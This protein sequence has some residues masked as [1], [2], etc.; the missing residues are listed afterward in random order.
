MFLHA[1]EISPSIRPNIVWITCEDM[2]PHLSCFGEKLINTPNLDKL[3]SD[4]VRYTNFYTVSGVCAP[5]R[6]SI[7]TG[8]YPTSIGAN[9]MRNYIPLKGVA[10]VKLEG[11]PASYS[12]VPPKEVKCFPE[13]LRKA[14]Y[15]C[16]NNPKED[17]QFQA[18]VTAWDESSP[19]A[20]WKNR[21]TNQPFFAVFNLE[22][23]HESQIWKRANFPLMVNP[24]EIKVPSYYPNVSEV[25]RDI[26]IHLS[27]VIEMDKQVGKLIKEL[28][29]AGLYEE[30]IIFFYSDHGDGLPYVKREI[31][32]RGLHVPL[33]IKFPKQKYAGTVDSSLLSAIDLAPSI[34]SLAHIKVP[35]YMQGRPFLGNINKPK[36]KFLFAARD[37]MD[38]HVDRVR[39]VF[40]ERFQYLRN[41][42]PELPYYQNLAYR[43]QMPS[44]S[45]IIE[46]RDSGMLNEV[47][48][49]WF[50]IKPKEELYDTKLDPNQLHNLINE[51]S[52]SKLA[53][54]MSAELDRWLLKYPDLNA[55]PE[56]QL[57]KKMW[58]GKLEVPHTADLKLKKIGSAFKVLCKTEGASIGYRIYK[59]G[60]NSNQQSFKV[61]QNELLRI[62]AD[63]E[64]EIQ[65]Q[66]IG[67]TASILKFS[68]NHK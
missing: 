21:S 15:Y 28:K 54:K 18:P 26:A 64:I 61:Y 11:V 42:F 59:K 50:S 67:Y 65:A 53:N 58:N 48:K 55:I 35:N 12:V 36:V 31:T 56:D 47:Q 14:G 57:R 38:E 68:F 40:D 30:T 52:F 39:T 19:K 32:K 16:T 2:S 45:R 29:D 46:L 49:R 9:N 8:M 6:N 10:E 13:Y 63:E 20:H 37:R 62:N 25:R 1:Q 66:R 44:M 27:N 7:I 17:Y 33:I 22:L 24:D 34:L 4:G 60:K 5:S 41:Y 23:T 3:A 43:L 51:P